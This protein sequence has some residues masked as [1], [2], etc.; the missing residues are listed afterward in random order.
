M[1]VAHFQHYYAASRLRLYEFH[2]FS[3]VIFP[4]YKVYT[5]PSVGAFLVSVQCRYAE[6]DGVE[7]NFITWLE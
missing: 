5:F 4:G 2:H 1:F 6:F 7:T 3:K